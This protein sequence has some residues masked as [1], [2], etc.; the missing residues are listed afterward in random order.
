MLRF[1]FWLIN[2]FWLLLLYLS[3][4]NL[5]FKRDLFRLSS[6]QNLKALFYFQKK[7]FV[8]NKLAPVPIIVFVPLIKNKFF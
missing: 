8:T 5:N 2:I 1:K 7:I 3:I 6:R 4:L